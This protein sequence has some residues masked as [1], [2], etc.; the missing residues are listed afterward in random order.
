MT[1]EHWPPNLPHFSPG[2]ALLVSLQPHGNLCWSSTM[3]STLLAEVIGSC[4]LYLKHYPN[5]PWQLESS[6]HWGACSQVTFSGSTSQNPP[7]ENIPCTIPLG[8]FPLPYFLPR[9]YVAVYFICFLNIFFMWAIFKVFIE[10]ITIILLFYVLVFCPRGMRD[11]S[12]LTRD[13]TCTSCIRRWGLNNW[14]DWE[15]PTLFSS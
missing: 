9:S 3:P 10:L 2:F 8:I 1:C 5:R 15:T 13:R 7:N 14:T 4:F 12:S 6:L 11:L